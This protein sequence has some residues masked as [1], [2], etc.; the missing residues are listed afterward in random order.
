MTQKQ[1]W[2]NP[3]LWVVALILI[4]VLWANVAQQE[5]PNEINALDKLAT[6]R[7]VTVGSSVRF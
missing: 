1:P 4:N 6:Y 3:L 2:L 7:D 5:A